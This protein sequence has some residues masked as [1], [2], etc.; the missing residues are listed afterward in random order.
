MIRIGSILFVAVV[1]TALAVDVSLPTSNDNLLHHRYEEFYQRT[2][3]PDDSAWQGGMYGL[4]RNARIRQGESV[5]TRFHEGIDIKPLYRDKRGDP[6]DSVR[7]IASGIVVYANERAGH[8]NYGKYVVVEHIWSGSPYYS[9]Y[10]HLQDIW[11]DS[12]DVVERGDPI[13]RLGYTGAGITRSRAHLHLEIC[14]LYNANFQVWYEEEHAATDTNRHGIFNGK[15]LAGMDPARFLRYMMDNPSHDVSDFLAREQTLYTVQFARNATGRLDLV[16]RYDWLLTREPEDSDQSW[17]VSF[18]GGGI[19]LRVEP[20]EEQ[21]DRPI[22][23]FVAEVPT[24]ITYASKRVLQRSGGYC[25]LSPAGDRLVA[26]LNSG[27]HD[28]ETPSARARGGAGDIEDE[29]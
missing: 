15:N 25:T 2:A 17:R 24:P 21:T 18:T 9:V 10:A 13:G 29:D 16:E 5:Y 27:E 26:L 19:P 6:L 7:T 4:V 11:I 28:D 20:V 8:S 22:V 14:M 1:Q 3:R 12:G 23:C